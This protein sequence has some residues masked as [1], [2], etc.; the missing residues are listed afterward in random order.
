VARGDQVHGIIPRALLASHRQNDDAAATLAELCVGKHLTVGPDTTVF[1]LLV[2]FAE[3][4]ADNAVVLAQ[5]RSRDGAGPRVL[6]L[7]TGARLRQ[8]V[9]EGAE[10]YSRR[11]EE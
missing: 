7:V 8:A 5:D 10:F 4:R 11:G 6:G 9:A 1:D 2:R 3:A